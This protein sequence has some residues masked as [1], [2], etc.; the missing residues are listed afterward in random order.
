MQ[1][2]FYEKHVH[3]DPDLPFLLF[4]GVSQQRVTNKI[5]HWHEDMEILQ[6]IENS[7]VVFCNGQRIEPRSGDIVIINP[8]ALHTV[9]TT[10]DRVSYYCLIVDKAFS[11]Q[12]K[13]PLSSMS[14]QML[15]EKDTNIDRLFLELIREMH[16]K[17]LFFKQRMQ[18]NVTN[19][20]IH[21]CR[22]YQ[23]NSRQVPEHAGNQKE[24]IVKNIIR[25]LQ[26]HFTEDIHVEQLSHELGFS[27]S[28]LCHVFK[29]ITTCTIVEYIQQLRCIYAMQLLTTMG[30]SVSEAAEQ[31]GFNNVSY[32]S[33]I[34]KRFMGHS[35]SKISG[36]NKAGR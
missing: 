12:Q 36:R 35:P 7:G 30:L 32:F 24:T 11:D 8:N 26:H 16:E 22:Q 17:H 6:F 19:L 29:E 33:K 4:D 20:L 23:N 1:K 2:P 14:F 18:A 9:C 25:Y 21:I 28:Y 5:L 3:A 31:A 13:L 10:A 27:Y 34:Y 15:V